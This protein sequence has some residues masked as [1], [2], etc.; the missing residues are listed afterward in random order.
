MSL[1]I[2]LY[3]LSVLLSMCSYLLPRVRQVWRPKNWKTE[4]RKE[5]RSNLRQEQ[6][7]PFDIPPLSFLFIFIS[8]WVSS[9]FNVSKSFL[10]CV[11]ISLRV[12]APEC[13]QS[14]FTTTSRWVLFVRKVFAATTYM[15]TLTRNNKPVF[16]LI[17]TEKMY[18]DLVSD[19]WPNDPKNS[20]AISHRY[21]Y[22]SQ[23][24]IL[25]VK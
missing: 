2:E 15:H 13:W 3:I 22:S 23:L 18:L 11:V 20:N 21:S 7:V 25:Y 5:K 16:I 17:F 1:S 8:C 19:L 6:F 10:S 4:K 9:F 12:L 14:W 24:P